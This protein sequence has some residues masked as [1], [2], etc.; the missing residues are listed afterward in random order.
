[1]RKVST[2]KIGSALKKIRNSFGYVQ[3]KL[4]EKIEACIK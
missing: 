1:M 2:I 3:E 4:A